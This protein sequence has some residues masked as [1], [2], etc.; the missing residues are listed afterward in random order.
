MGVAF[1]GKKMETLPK[2]H[3]NGNDHLNKL[4]RVL[5]GKLGVLELHFVSLFVVRPSFCHTLLV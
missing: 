1:K 3:G 2:G 5:L 4:K